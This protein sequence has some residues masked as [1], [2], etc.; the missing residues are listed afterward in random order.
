MISQVSEPIALSAGNIGRMFGISA[1]QV[2][3]WHAAGTLGPVPVALSER[4]TRWDAEEVREW[5]AACR[6]AG[7]IVPRSEWLQQE[8]GKS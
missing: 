8:G 7:R 5:W 2:Y 3:A 1:R 4:V 6:A